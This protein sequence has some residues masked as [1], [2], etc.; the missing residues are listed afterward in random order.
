MLQPKWYRVHFFRK[1]SET[2]KMEKLKELR[3]DYDIDFVGLS[4]ANKDLRC[5]GSYDKSIWGATK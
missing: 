4:E 3:R 2:I 5:C 1:E